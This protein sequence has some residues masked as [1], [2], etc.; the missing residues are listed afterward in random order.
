[1]G[2]TQPREYKLRSYSEENVSAPVYKSENTAVRICRAEYVTPLDLQKF[3]VTSR[4]SGG[5]LIGIVRSRTQA[6]QFV[7]CC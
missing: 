6:T 4:T 5:R 3:V 1:M 2:S 7:Y